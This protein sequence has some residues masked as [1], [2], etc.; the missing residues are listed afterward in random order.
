MN[1]DVTIDSE[2]VL[3]SAGSADREG[4][5]LLLLLHGYNS[6]EGDL[7]GLAP[8]LP[9]Q[10]AIASL[11]APLRADFGHAWFPLT[12]E[13]LEKAV[14][15]ADDAAHAILAWLDALD[16]QPASVGLL[17]F[18]QGGA[19]AIELL[20]AAP[21]RFE[22]AVNL[23]GFALPGARDGDEALAATRPP[24]LWAR[25]TDDTVIPP[26]AIARTNRWLPAHVDLT[27]RIYEGVGHSVSQGELDDVVE[28]LRARYASAQDR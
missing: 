13:G 26:E 24:V 9:L 6:H 7:F 11:R 25:G 4:R 16:P 1:P 20:R 22:F 18:S 27:E 17:G 8:Y 21:H 5:P 3:W 10:P 19:I 15:G 12:A 23:A 28:F 2:A 14:E